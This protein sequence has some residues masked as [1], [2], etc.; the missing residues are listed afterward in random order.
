MSGGR[1]FSPRRFRELALFVLSKAPDGLTEQ[2]LANLLFRIDFEA[3]R[4]LG[5]S[6][7]GAT[8]VKMP[9]GASPARLSRRPG[10]DR[11]L[12]ENRAA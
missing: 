3:Y 8:Y 12:R 11:R 9:W 7:T 4:L 10:A 2:Q 5:R 1:V 6:I